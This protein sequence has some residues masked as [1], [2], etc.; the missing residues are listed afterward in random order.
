MTTLTVMWNNGDQ[1]DSRETQLQPDT[2]LAYDY[3]ESFRRKQALE[4]EK[5]LMEA[6]LADAI[7]IYRLYAFA[8][9]LE[10][11]RR[12]SEARRWLWSDDWRWPFSYRNV[13]E[14]LGLDPGYLRR[15]LM[16]GKT[17][18]SAERHVKIKPSASNNG[19]SNANRAATAFI[20]IRS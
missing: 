17:I 12:F 9:S 13:C 8:E 3:F 20:W 16:H 19:R 10:K 5:Q 14:V 11:T 7:N 1:V 2:L 18:S 15:G 6:M 4:P